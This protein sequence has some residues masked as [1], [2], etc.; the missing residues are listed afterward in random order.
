[1]T[2][3]SFTRDYRRGQILEILADP[4]LRVGSQAE[5]VELL[6]RRGITATQ[7]NISRD[8]QALRVQRIN[9]RYQVCDWSPKTDPEFQRIMDL[10]EGARPVGPYMVVV[11]TVEGS[12]HAV[13]RAIQNAKW[14]EVGGVLGGENTVFI[15]TASQE[16]TSKVS[17]RFRTFLI[18]VEED[19]DS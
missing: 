14:E 16:D 9:G 2:T 8:L 5:L 15:A 11:E 4:A 7:S 13:G 1:M 19:E 18:P 17:K 3:S 6:A 12:G 10:I